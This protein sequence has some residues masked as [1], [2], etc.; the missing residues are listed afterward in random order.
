MSKMEKIY[1][2]FIKITSLIKEN[3][4]WMIFQ[5]LPGS[6][7]QE[8]KSGV[9]S[10][11]PVFNHWFVQPLCKTSTHS[12]HRIS[13]LVVKWLSKETGHYLSHVLRFGAHVL[14]QHEKLIPHPATLNSLEM[15][16]LPWQVDNIFSRFCG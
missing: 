8:L 2:D 6:L 14:L 12:V 11:F 15:R 9:L 16:S 10:L 1:I 7:S 4:H 3:R 5:S 13:P